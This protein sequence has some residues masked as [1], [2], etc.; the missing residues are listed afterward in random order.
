MLV[1]LISGLLLDLLSERFG[2]ISK[3]WHSLVEINSFIQLFTDWLS[4]FHS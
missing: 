1:I 2:K 4:L 3:N